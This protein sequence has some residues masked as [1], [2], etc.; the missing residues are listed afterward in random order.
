MFSLARSRY[1]LLTQFTFLAINGLAV[2]LSTIYNT[3]TPDLYPGNA[4]HKIGWIITWVVSA[5]VLISLVGVVSGVIRGH[6]SARA[7]EERSFIPMAQSSDEQHVCL[8]NYRLSNDSGQG[9]EPTTESVRSNS[10]STTLSDDEGLY[11]PHKE[12][13]DFEDM[14]LS[15]PVHKGF[16]T[17]KAVAF[18]SSRVWRY[19][20]VCYQIIDRMILPFGFIALT[21]GIVVFGRFFV[22][23][24]LPFLLLFLFLG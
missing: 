13:D 21:T 4:H 6:S 5:Q 24:L 12:Y 11:Q 15:S 18:A 8:D 14:P 2:L 1:T 20:E 23:R 7:A 22:R 17:A 16:F 9:T 3:Q 19:V 10:V